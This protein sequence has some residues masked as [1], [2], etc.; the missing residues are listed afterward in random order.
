MEKRWILHP[1]DEGQ[2]NALAVEL[3]VSPL[4]A[5]L[6]LTRGVAVPADA[7]RF[8]SPALADLHDPFLLPDMDRTV[9]R[10]DRALAAGERLM[11]YGDYD[12]DGIT[13]TALLVRGLARL[14]ADVGWYLPNRSREGYGISAAGIDEAARR[15]VALVISVDCG[16]TAHA[17][18]DYA[19]QLGIDVVVTDHHETK[20]SLPAACAVV[21]PKRADSA[22][23]YQELAGVGVAYKLLQALCRRHGLPEADLEADLDLVALG[24]VADIVP[25]TG[26]NRVLA[27]F[28]LEA[29]RRSGKPGI[30][31]LLEVTGLRDRPLDSGQIVFMLA[32]RIN[33][34]GRMGDAGTALRLLLT[35]DAAEAAAIAR[36]LDEEN[37]RRKAVDDEILEQAVA[38]VGSDVDLERDK[39]IVLASESWHQGVIGIVASRLVE[40][41]YRPTVLI[42]VDGDRGKGSA[43][44]IANF[45]L[46]EALKECQDLLLGFGGHK[47]AAGLSIEAG[48]I[49]AFRERLNEV[50]GRTLSA[51]D[52]VP[53]QPLDAEVDLDALDA[54][55]ARGF[56]RFA[57]FGP[58]NRHP[59]LAA[60]RSRVV[61]SPCI[62]G[63]NHLKFKVKHRQRIFD[64]IGFSLGGMLAEVEDPDAAVDLAFV[65]EENEW[66]G[67]TRLQLRIKD[68][69]V[70]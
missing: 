23:P 66:Q 9:D 20:D 61:G 24:T 49:P 10:V 32:P 14:G 36:D 44:S 16:I 34:A 70:G 51:E 11:V 57:P 29:L 5:R 48:R 55:T 39:V 53:C 59:V 30:R 47:F 25:L 43:R 3:G 27:K 8:L 13:A 26:E 68:I 2:A 31:A 7:R 56:A 45:H 40:Q 60:M 63:R 67:R 54:E 18:I 69:R 38:L 21:D 65:L 33:A 19:R 35:G 50:A 17:E 62:V 37:K 4:I 41:F 15:G 1:A 52:F 58:G 12:V 42:A 6:L 46:H 64:S 28:G 22:Y